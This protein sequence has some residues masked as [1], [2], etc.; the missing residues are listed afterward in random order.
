MQCLQCGAKWIQGNKMLL[1]ESCPICDCNYKINPELKKY[2]KI[3]ELLLELILEKGIDFCKNQQNINA[4][5]NDY[6]P[7]QEVIRENIKMLL[8][9]GVGEFV[10]DYRNGVRTI[11]VESY[12]SSISSVIDKSS[13]INVLEYLCEAK[14]FAGSDFKTETFYLEQ[15]EEIAEDKYKIICLEKA[16]SINNSEDIS[17]RLADFNLSIGKIDIGIKMLQD[18]A[19]KNHLNSTLKLASIYK[20][21]ELKAIEL[22]EKASSNGSSEATFLLGCEYLFGSDKIQNNSRA[23]E[24]FEKVAG[25]SYPEAHYYLYKLYYKHSESKSKAL[26]HLRLAAD[27]NDLSAKYEY[28][29]HLL[30]GDDMQENIGL[31]VR[32]LE[33]CAEK[34]NIS[35]IQKLSFMYMTG[36]KVAKDKQKAKIYKE[37]LEDK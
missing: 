15:F 30:Y 11:S 19:D 20:T 21:D 7:E 8:E 24:C 37:K 22:L 25:D 14:E 32:L 17:Y 6:F 3:Q 9:Q 34:N 1:L 35:A 4:Y 29:I 23:E 36:F 12:C 31:A 33:E 27:L 16:R 26:E 2:N 18:L 13:I 10:Y 5:L 28:A